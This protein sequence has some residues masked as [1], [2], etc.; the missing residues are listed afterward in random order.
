MKMYL[1]RNRRQNSDQMGTMDSYI[2]AYKLSHESYQT[3]QEEDTSRIAKENE[4]ALS[5]RSKRE[6][7][8]DPPHEKDFIKFELTDAI[9]PDAETLKNRKISVGKNL[10]LPFE[11]SDTLVVFG[12]KTKGEHVSKPASTTTEAPSTNS[13]STVKSPRT[14]RRRVRKVKAA[15]EAAP[16]K[17]KRDS[18]SDMAN[19]ESRKI[20]VYVTAPG[21]QKHESLPIGVQKAINRVLS[22]NAKARV[23][24]SKPTKS[25]KSD[26]DKLT[27]YD[28]SQ[29]PRESIKSSNSLKDASSDEWHPISA[30]GSLGRYPAINSDKA[31]DYLTF[32]PVKN[33]KTVVYGKPVSEIQKQQ[34]PSVVTKYVSVP[35][36]QYVIKEVPVHYKVPE[37]P[38]ITL[39]PNIKITYDAKDDISNVKISSTPA[40]FSETFSE[41]Q[42]AN[43]NEQSKSYSKFISST[44]GTKTVIDHS[45]GIKNSN[46]NFK[47]ESLTN[48]LGKEPEF[49]IK[50][51]SQILEGTK[52]G[53]PQENKS[54]ILFHP[55]GTK[56]PE[57]LTKLNIKVLDFPEQKPNKIEPISLDEFNKLYGGESGV[58]LPTD[59]FNLPRPFT[60]IHEPNPEYEISIPFSDKFTDLDTRKPTSNINF[61]K[62]FSHHDHKS[63]GI[64]AGYETDSDVSRNVNALFFI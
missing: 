48:L 23:S 50:G 45:E 28:K 29:K 24:K 46:N 2:E 27:F 53:L 47:L 42:T 18:S 49:Q 63:S 19:S 31:P 15:T 43:Q 57:P 60:P 40:S 34:T 11:I 33:Y 56:G 7:S 32:V 1:T 58:K 16:T 59:N 54:P 38:K 55:H 62:P 4:K 10:R 52:Y 3:R 22:K 9:Q 44:T 5:S 37:Q 17:V 26:G 36:I 64:S 21:N 39:T 13:N 61:D 20:K 30:I 25:T 8:A 35:Q 51:L 41:S 14:R 6:A 12:N